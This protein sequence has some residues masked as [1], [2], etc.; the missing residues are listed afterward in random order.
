MKERIEIDLAPYIRQ[1][2]GLGAALYYIDEGRQAAKD[3]KVVTLG[4]KHI[5]L[6]VPEGIQFGEGFLKGLLGPLARKVGPE[7]LEVTVE[8]G[9]KS[10]PY[11]RHYWFGNRV[12]S[13]EIVRR[14]L[15]IEAERIKKRAAKKAKDSKNA[16][17][18]EPITFFVP[19][20][21]T[22]L[23]LEEDWAFRLYCE[24]RNSGLYE[25]L[26]K[27]YKDGNPWNWRRRSL[28][29]G[30]VVMKAGAILTV[31]R[32][33][34]RVGVKEYSSL[35]FNVKKGAVVVT[36][37]GETTLKKGAR[38]WAKLKDV[39]QMKVVVNKNSLAGN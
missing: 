32:I 7:N 10:D 35:T 16:D 17:W 22:S 4:D 39:N 31:S 15:S 34:I 11:N 18:S 9:Y 1:A 8:G 30:D 13:Q 25:Q 33:Y 24:H 28:E 26:P 29:R 21:G 20:I 37:Q 38:F 2:G 27:L 19:E 6:K 5:V 36:N 3:H 12:S 14:Y 23:R